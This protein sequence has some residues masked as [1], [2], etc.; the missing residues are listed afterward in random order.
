MS[1]SSISQG[2][3]KEKGWPNE[4]DEGKH[5]YVVGVWLVVGRDEKEALAQFF[6]YNAITIPGKLD[7]EL[8]LVDAETGRLHP[9]RLP[10][11]RVMKEG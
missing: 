1:L 3:P 8:A 5:Y 7:V 9:Y 10:N 6:K 4:T 2:D 11:E